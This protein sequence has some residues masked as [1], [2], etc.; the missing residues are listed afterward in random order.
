MTRKLHVASWWP[1]PDACARPEIIRREESSSKPHSGS[2]FFTI[3][4]CVPNEGGQVSGEQIYQVRKQRMKSSL[5]QK[6]SAHTTSNWLVGEINK[7]SIFVTLCIC[8][9]Y[10]GPRFP[11]YKTTMLKHAPSNTV[12]GIMLLFRYQ[13]VPSLLSSSTWKEKKKN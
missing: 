5:F 10:R 2:V 4:L 11:V 3:T 8:D 12:P 1:P 6:L 9:S 13:T 7:F